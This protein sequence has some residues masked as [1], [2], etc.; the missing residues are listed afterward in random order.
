MSKLKGK[1]SFQRLLKTHTHKRFKQISGKTNVK[2]TTRKE[3]F[4]NDSFL[5]HTNITNYNTFRDPG[6]ATTNFISSFV[7]MKQQDDGKSEA[8][9]SYKQ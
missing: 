4:V 5:S 3:I 9:T 7:F 2:S 8:R 6:Y 1:T